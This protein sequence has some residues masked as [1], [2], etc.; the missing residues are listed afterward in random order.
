MKYKKSTR[1]E[2]SKVRVKWK[3]EIHIHL[4]V[5]IKLYG[6]RVVGV[7]EKLWQVE[8]QGVPYK[9]DSLNKVRDGQRAG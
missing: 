9:E 8:R 1:E 2:Q 5:Q 6:G 7:W 3:T 4:K